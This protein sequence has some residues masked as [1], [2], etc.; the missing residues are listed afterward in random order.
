MVGYQGFFKLHTCVCVC[1]IVYIYMGV[2]E[3]NDTPSLIHL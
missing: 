3:Q 1:I 2:Y